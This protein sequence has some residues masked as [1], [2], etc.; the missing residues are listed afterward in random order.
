MRMPISLVRRATEYD[1]V[2][3]SPIEASSSASIPKKLASVKT[4]RS[5]NND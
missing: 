3:Y 2:P 4:R 5:S 1:M